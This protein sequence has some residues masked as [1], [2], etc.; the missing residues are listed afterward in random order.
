MD[1]YEG[2]VMTYLAIAFATIICGFVIFMTEFT[3]VKY[4]CRNMSYPNAID[5]PK[6]VIQQCKKEK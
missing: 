4:D 6:T 1:L 2:M 3:T 5:I